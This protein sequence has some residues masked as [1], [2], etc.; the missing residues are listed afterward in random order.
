MIE[1]GGESRSS[2]ADRFSLNWWKS[3]RQMR[4]IE[5]ALAEIE[6]PKVPSEARDVWFNFPPM[7]SSSKR[8]VAQPRPLS[9]IV[10]TVVMVFLIYLKGGA[11]A[12]AEAVQDAAR[13]PAVPN[14]GTNL[15]LP[16]GPDIFLI[17]F[18]AVAVIA[19]GLAVYLA[20]KKSSKNDLGEIRELLL[21]MI[22]TTAL[23]LLL[24][25][26]HRVPV[27]DTL[28][29]LTMP[30]LFLALVFYATVGLLMHQS[31]AYGLKAWAKHIGWL[32]FAV[33]FAAGLYGWWISPLLAD[34]ARVFWLI[35]IIEG[36]ILAPIWIRRNL[37]S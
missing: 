16:T 30:G 31:Q 14:I 13:P 6:V 32:L 19:L 26:A 25:L 33:F 12:L 9:A 11:S 36:W 18:G 10:A 3:R 22:I 28:L 21:W 23:V 27:I 29:A 4:K 8:Q 20:W 17:V 7:A 5:H 34:R 1:H 37:T 15:V 2:W 24:P 35:A